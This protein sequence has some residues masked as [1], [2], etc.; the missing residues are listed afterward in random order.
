MIT[1]MWLPKWKAYSVRRNGR[2]LGLVR[3]KVPLPF[4][5]VAEFA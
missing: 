3:C 4:L 5:Q 1:L 2:L